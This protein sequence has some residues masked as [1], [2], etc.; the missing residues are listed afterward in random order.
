MSVYRA[1][2]AKGSPRYAHDYGR[3]CCA[4]VY[5]TPVAIV[6]PEQGLLQQ[7]LLQD[8][9]SAQSEQLYSMHQQPADEP[10]LSY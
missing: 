8:W 10:V 6:S 7:K 1:W 9:H 3:Y 2:K 4:I 5:D